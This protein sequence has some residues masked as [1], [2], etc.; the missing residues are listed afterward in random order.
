MEPEPISASKSYP[1]ARTVK[2]KAV[3]LFGRS[4]EKSVATYVKYQIGSFEMIVISLNLLSNLRAPNISENAMNDDDVKIVHNM[5]CLKKIADEQKSP[6]GKCLHTRNCVQQCE[7]YR[8][9]AKEY[10][11]R[12]R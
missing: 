2:R 1:L 12:K 10:L 3:L 5:E 4:S 9:W 8:K 6:C 11:R 7:P